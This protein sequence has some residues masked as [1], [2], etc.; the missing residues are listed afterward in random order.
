MSKNRVELYEELLPDGRC[1]YRL[2]YTDKMTGK[3][4]RLTITME[5]R[6]ASN[7]KLAL[8]TLQEKL[9]KIMLEADGKEA[10]LGDVV[11]VYLKERA[12]ILKP[13]TTLRNASVLHNMANILGDDVYLSQLTVPYIKSKLTA[14]T[15]KPV[16]YNEYIKRFKAFL[17]WCYINDY[18]DSQNLSNKLLVMPDNKRTRIAEKYLERNELQAL[19]E[20]SEHPLWTLVIHFLALSGLRIG[21][22]IALTNADIDEEYIHVDKTYEV[23]AKVLSHEPK[24]ATSVRDVYLRPELKKV[25]KDIQ[26]Y[27]R[28][29]NFEQ[30]IRSD[31]FVCD[32]KGLYMHYDAFRKYLG[33]LSERVIGRKITPHA[34]RHTTASLLIADGIPLEVVSRMLGHDGSRITK[35][36]YIHITQELKNRDKEILS[37][38]TVL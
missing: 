34:L 28:V 26:S 7:Y 2:P 29:H 12:Q 9:D 30:G 21:E 35:Q 18:L 24:T 33:E 17:S 14:Y 20:A 25:T 22:L 36:I 5:S 27:M 19:L 38:A 23:G 8:R 15:T 11:E 13:S 16:T 10:L 32:D 3:E 31:L 4:K 37:K 6:S 1:R